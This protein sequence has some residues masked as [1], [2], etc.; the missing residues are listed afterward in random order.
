VNGSEKSVMLPEHLWRA[1]D[2]MVN[3]GALPPDVLVRQAVEQFVALQGYDVPMPGARL[4]LSPEPVT[5]QP[6]S[7]EP[8]TAQPLSPEPVTAQ[9]IPPPA[10]SPPPPPPKIE[11]V[12]P[13]AKL[14]P[15]STPPPPNPTPAAPAPLMDDEPDEYGD[16]M[17]RVRA[18]SGVAPALTN[19]SEAHKPERSAPQPAHEPGAGPEWVRRAALIDADSDRTAARE[20]MQAI[21]SDLGKLTLERATT[22]SLSEVDPEEGDS[23]AADS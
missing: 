4:P 15:A 7:P 1:L 20:R 17:T 13:A 22:S 6:L 8:V 23:E 12:A 18:P 19:V 14:R 9:P 5:A 3:D 2:D 21:D 16:A 10:A 11:P